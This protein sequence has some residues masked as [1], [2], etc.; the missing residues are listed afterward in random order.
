MTYYNIAFKYGVDAFVEAMAV[1]NIRGAIAADLPPEEGLAYR[2]AMRANGLSPV[3]LFSPTSSD[4]RMRYIA[5]HADGFIYC[6]A[7][8]G[9]TGRTRRSQPKW[10]T[11]SDAAARPRRS[12]SR[13]AS[14]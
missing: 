7:R 13:W 3:Y 2:N 8:K 1:R 14:G 12:P 11:I 5:S 10:T 4:T 9:V 6:V